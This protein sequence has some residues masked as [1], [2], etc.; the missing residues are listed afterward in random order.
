[1]HWPDPSK[2]KSNV[3]TVSSMY[4]R[5]R[6]PGPNMSNQRRYLLKTARCSSL[7]VVLKTLRLM[8]RAAVLGCV[9]LVGMLSQGGSFLTGML[10]E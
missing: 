6:Q 9:H 4:T 2:T 3:G 10:S 7:Q 1:M 8:Q 5:P